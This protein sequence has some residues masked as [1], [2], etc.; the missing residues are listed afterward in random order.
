[1]LSSRRLARVLLTVGVSVGVVAAA[2]AS[3]EEADTIEFGSVKDASGGTTTSEA[4][5]PPG[6]GSCTVEFCP[7]GGPGTPCCIS[8]QGPC[9]VNLGTGCTTPPTADF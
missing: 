5:L 6:T 4:S 1:M 2:C 9:G 3:S 7:S 8:P